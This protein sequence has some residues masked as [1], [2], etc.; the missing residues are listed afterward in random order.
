MS[1]GARSASAS[2]GGGGADAEGDSVLL[3]LPRMRAAIEAAVAETEA[4]EEGQR[5]QRLAALRLRWHPDRNPVL[6]ELATEVSKTLNAAIDASA[7]RLAA[8]HSGDA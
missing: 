3:S 6:Q 5:K 8:A 2:G 7:A 1:G 4:M